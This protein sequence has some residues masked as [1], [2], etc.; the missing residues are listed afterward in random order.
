MANTMLIV[1]MIITILLLFT[2]MIF[3]AMASDKASGIK[4][5]KSTNAVKSGSCDPKKQYQCHRNSMYS[6]L[7]TGVAVALFAV[8]LGIYIYT[9]RGEIVQQAHTY[10]GQYVPSST[11]SVPISTKQL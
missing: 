4:W 6:A 8:I 1:F 7:V 2:A 10:I 11:S 9:S 3:S 5:D